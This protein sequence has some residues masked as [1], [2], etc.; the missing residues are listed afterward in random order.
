MLFTQSVYLTSWPLVVYFLFFVP[1]TP[2]L[3]FEDIS[4]SAISGA[5]VGIG[6][7]RFACRVL[8]CDQVVLPGPN[9][10]ALKASVSL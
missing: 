3:V 9:F 10:N 7:R 6:S 5:G 2:G 8:E 4:E 1:N